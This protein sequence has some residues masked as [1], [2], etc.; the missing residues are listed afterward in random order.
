MRLVRT[1]PQAMALAHGANAILDEGHVRAQGR[2]L[3]PQA[4]ESAQ[5]V[6]GTLPPM[7]NLF[8]HLQAMHD[9]KVWPGKSG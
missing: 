7:Q 3:V 6:D 4:P 8:P 1:S 9:S 2:E 5:G